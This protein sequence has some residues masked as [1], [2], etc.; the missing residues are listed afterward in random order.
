V[1]SFLENP[2]SSHYLGESAR[3]LNMDPMTVK[4]ALD[5]LVKDDLL[6]RTEEK[7]QI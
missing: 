6:I 4:R 1:Y 5:L 7:K 2:H 3:M